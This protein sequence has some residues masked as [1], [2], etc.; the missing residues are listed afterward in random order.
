MTQIQGPAYT[1]QTSC[2]L[3]DVKEVL[4][5]L[6]PGAL[7]GAR[8]VQEG[9]GEVLIELSRVMPIHGE[10]AEIRS[11]VYARVVDA[12][13]HLEK[14]ATYEIVLSKLLEVVQETRGQLTNNREHDLRVIAA[15]AMETATRQDKP[16]LL[17]LFEKTIAYRSQSA[18]KGV[19][20][21]KKNRAPK[22][23]HQAPEST[24]HT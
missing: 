15:R 19:K 9:I 2:D 6:A 12:T 11:A 8:N 5:D 21:R 13:K 17:A 3:A 23:E 22:T 18:N 16:E 1:G 4:V 24:V 14:L 10:E 20:T 7:K